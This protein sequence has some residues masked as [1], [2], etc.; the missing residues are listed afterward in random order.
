VPSANAQHDDQRSL[1]FSSYEQARAQFRWHI[2]ERFNIGT[3]V[4]DV[5]AERGPNRPAVI[6]RELSG[7]T[8]AWS[9]ADLR[10]ESNRLANLL[11]ALGVSAGDRVAILLP[12]RFETALTHIA[13]YK[14]AGIAI[15]LFTQFGAAALQHRLEDSGASVLVTDEA[16]R[17]VIESIRVNLAMLRDIIYVDGPDRRRALLERIAQFPADFAARDTAANDPALLIYTSG[18]TGASKGALH[19]HRVLLGHLPGVA[20]SHGGLPRQDACMW[21]PADWAWIGGLLDVLLPAL[22]WGIPV[23]ACRFPKFD[24]EA[25]FELLA[26]CKVTNTFLPPTALRMMKSVPAPGTRWPLALRSIASGGESLGAQMLDWGRSELGISINEFYG[27]TE[28]NVLVSSCSEWFEPVPGMLGKAVPGHDVVVLG[29]DGEL[30]SAGVL[31]EIAVRRPD[32]VMFLGYWNAQETTAAK[33]A[34]E[35]LLT[36]DLGVVEKEGFIRFI[37]RADDLITS[38]GYRIGPVE[39]EDCLSRHPAVLAAAVVGVADEIR[40]ESVAAFIVPRPGF[41]SSASLSAELQD[42]VAQKLGHYLRPR[43]VRY[44]TEL[45]LT[46]TGKVMRNR[47]REMLNAPQPG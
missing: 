7:P 25:A 13:V 46:A 29:P 23:V 18:T 17:P 47:L 35:W 2:P 42:H 38:G 32:P 1:G 8:R 39:I 37:G 19:A 24:P 21:T 30:A 5:W 41:E 12:Q 10:D 15:P 3:A 40:T 4:C 16:R 20:M 26:D 27:Q 44:V 43:I 6:E 34:G 31:G 11:T 36:G 9:F 14:A 33:F 45:P 22:Y 28:C